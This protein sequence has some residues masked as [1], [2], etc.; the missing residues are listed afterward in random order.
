MAF[1][2]PHGLQDPLRQALLSHSTGARQ[3]VGLD[4]FD[5]GGAFVDALRACAVAS[6]ATANMDKSSSKI[7]MIMRSAIQ[8]SKA[9]SAMPDG[10][11]RC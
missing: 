9:S 8:K 7:C 11:K 10:S 2:L 6:R 3:G 1:R 5:H 4:G